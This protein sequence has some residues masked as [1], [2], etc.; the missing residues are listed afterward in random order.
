MDIVKLIIG[1]L[2]YNLTS[3]EEAHFR[4]W[5]DESEI[6]KSMFFRL[7]RLKSRENNF[8][9]VMDLDI[10]LAWGNVIKRLE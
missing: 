3:E 8:S 10:R 1:K 4:N 5:I 6:N 7:E 9:K 2:D